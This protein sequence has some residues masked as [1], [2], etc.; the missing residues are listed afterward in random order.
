LN[1]KAAYALA[2]AEAVKSSADSALLRM[3]TPMTGPLDAQGRS[4]AWMVEFF[5]PATKKSHVVYLTKGAMTC[6]TTAVDGPFVAQPIEETEETIFDTARLAGI[7]REAGGSALGAEAA[8]IT[9]SFMR[10]GPDAPAI[11]TISYVTRQGRPVLSVSID[12]KSGAVLGK[13]PR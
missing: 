6:T 5:A 13:T 12:G 7:A 10:S 2:K 1:G 11:W 9:A 3:L 8:T 4:S